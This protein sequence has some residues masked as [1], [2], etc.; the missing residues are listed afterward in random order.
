MSE[1]KFHPISFGKMNRYY[2]FPFITPVFSMMRSAIIF[3]IK[4]ENKDLE[5]SLFFLILS[6]LAYTGCGIILFL[7]S[8]CSKRKKVKSI[9][10][11]NGIE[12]GSIELSNSI[13]D[14]SLSISKK[15][16]GSNY[17]IK[18]FLILAL[19]AVSP[20]LNLPFG[21]FAFDSNTLQ[22]RYYCFLFIPLLSKWLLGIKIYKHQILGI[23]LALSGFIIFMILFF[24]DD[25]DPNIWDNLRFLTSCLLFSLHMVLVK[26]LTIKYYFFSPGKIYISIGIIMLFLTIFGSIIYSFIKYEDLTFFKISFDFSKNAMGALFYICSMANFALHIIYNIMTFSVIFYFNPNLYIIS[27]IFRPLLFWLFKIVYDSTIE[28]TYSYIFKSIGY[29]IQFISALI[30]NEIIIF[31]FCG[32]NVHTIKGLQDRLKSDIN[33][34]TLDDDE[35]NRDTTIEMEGGYNI[36]IDKTRTQKSLGLLNPNDN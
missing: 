26:Y 22:N 30:Y 35:E 17:K 9:Y 23:L 1:E 14:F 10:I 5:L 36:K 25:Q 8:F 7:L 6:S 18:L 21:F 3:I 4:K 32:L 33:L 20:I 16:V 12:D 11:E 13:S 28:N 24:F 27:D 2:I 19:M 29:L 15:A 34:L 31:N